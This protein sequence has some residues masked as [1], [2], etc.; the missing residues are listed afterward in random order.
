MHNFLVN[1]VC[2]AI[3]SI[4][5]IERAGEIVKFLTLVVLSSSKSCI[6][7]IQVWDYALGS[8]NFNDQWQSFVSHL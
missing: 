8:A 6:L 5:G 4:S 7:V 3:N 1:F 2:V